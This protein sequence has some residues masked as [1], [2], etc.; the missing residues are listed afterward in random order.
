MSSSP[1]S[2]CCVPPHIIPW[3]VLSLGITPREHQIHV[4]S[5]L[6][7]GIEFS[8]LPSQVEDGTSYAINER[9]MTKEPLVTLEMA[10][11]PIS[12][13]S[14]VFALYLSGRSQ[15]WRGLDA[16]E[17]FHK[18]TQFSMVSGAVAQSWLD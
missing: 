16:S 10:K 13:V 12:A 11:L 3:Q 5:T 18:Q 6:G 17:S 9:I 7:R 8:A 4:A 1:T 2:V 15:M 14:V